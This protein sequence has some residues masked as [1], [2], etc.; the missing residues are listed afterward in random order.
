MM[1]I[2]ILLY[3]K[4][5]TLL[6]TVEKQPLLWGLR[7][8]VSTLLHLLAGI[9]S[10]TRGE[11]CLEQ[12]NFD[13]LSDQQMARL[14]NHSLGFIY[15]FHHLLPEMSALENVAM[16]LLIAR[17][18]YREAC[19]KAEEALA[20]VS[21]SH[22]AKHKPSQL[23]GGE[24]Q[25]VAIARAVVHKPSAVLADEPTGNLDRKTAD[26]TLELLLQLNQDLGMALLVVTHDQMIANQLQ[27]QYNIENGQLYPHS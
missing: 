22:R 17:H 7:G 3:Y 16:P 27:S 14:R 5:L 10:A 2:V 18:H 12:Q 6:C 11:V 26:E 23:S 25:R 21:L 24:R 8:Q 19:A 4:A 15:Q 13:H 1:V 20:W 9:D